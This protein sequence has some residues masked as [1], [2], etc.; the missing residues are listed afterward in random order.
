MKRL[1]TINTT[2]IK[3]CIN[4]I[5]IVFI[6]FYFGLILLYPKAFI[7][8]KNIS[9]VRGFYS[10]DKTNIMFHVSLITWIMYN[11]VPIFYLSFAFCKHFESSYYYFIR[12]ENRGKWLLTYV[13]KAI[14]IIFLCQLFKTI[15]LTLYF[16]QPISIDPL[17]FI[18]DVLYSLTLFVVYLVGFVY[19]KRNQSFILI[20]ISYILLCFVDTNLYGW[21]LLSNFHLIELAIYILVI[22][23][24]F[25]SVVHCLNHRLDKIDLS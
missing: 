11:L 18:R 5:D 21:F 10:M 19:I 22:A 20:T 7:L 13:F 16:R 12:I 9:Y 23:V 2:Y 4:R 8:V 17:I 14:I 6:L 25:Y 3:S 1:S 15:D 24:C